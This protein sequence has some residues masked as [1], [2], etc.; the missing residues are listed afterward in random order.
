M[1]TL[2]RPLP[3][4]IGELPPSAQQL[5]RDFVERL[6]AK[7]ARKASNNKINLSW[8]GALREQ[9]QTYTSLDLQKKS[10]EWRSEI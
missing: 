9:R 2:A 5:V 7:Q 8:A 10:L 6:L 4:M 1:N 3:D